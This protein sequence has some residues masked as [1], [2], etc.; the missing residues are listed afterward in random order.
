MGPMKTI[1]DS[2]CI[3]LTPLEREQ[4]FADRYNEKTGHM[5]D[6]D[7]TRCQNRGFTAIVHEGLMTLKSCECQ[8]V[9]DMIQSAKYESGFGELLYA[10]LEDF[11]AREDWQRNLLSLAKDYLEAGF[12]AWFVVLGQSGSGK[13]LICSAICNRL[14]KQYRQVKYLSWV[15]FVGAMKKHKDFDYEA[16]AKAEILYVDD[17]LKGNLHPWDIQIAWQLLNDRYNAKLPTL[18]SSE[19][20]MGDLLD[21]DEALAGRIMERAGKYCIPIRKDRARNYRFRR[22]DHD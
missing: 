7:C 16:Y 2:P 18:I 6:F 19:L 1:K 10:K 21:A 8:Q 4:Y 12:D 22:T 14:L 3:D 13:T 11:Q 17:L 15:D 20:L 5:K 9:R